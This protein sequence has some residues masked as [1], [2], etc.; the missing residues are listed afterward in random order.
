MNNAPSF[1]VDT[2]E[3]PE[4]FVVEL[5][6]KDK[7]PHEFQDDIFVAGLIPGDFKGSALGPFN[8]LRSKA[9]NAMGFKF[10]CLSSDEIESLFQTG[11]Y[12]GVDTDVILYVWSRLQAEST[13]Y[14]AIRLPDVAFANAMKWAEKEEL[15]PGTPWFDDAVMGMLNDLVANARAKGKYKSQSDTSSK[16]STRGN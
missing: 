3:N 4:D 8:F 15:E 11:F 7:D 12:K 2:D 6:G 10:V 13:I 16:R 1:E 14:K 5:P 9:V